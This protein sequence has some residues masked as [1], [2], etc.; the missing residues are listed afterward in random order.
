MLM[1][2]GRRGKGKSIAVTEIVL[3]RLRHHEKVYT[4]FPVAWVKGGQVVAQAGYVGSL[5]DCLDL[6]DCTIVVDEAPAWASVR[7]WQLLPSKVITDWMQS[8]K[9]HVQWVF[10]GTHEARVDVII[11]ELV[12]WV[13]LCSRVWW[14]PRWVP[15]FALCQTYYEDINEARRHK[16]GRRY[17][18]WYKQ[19][20]FDSYATDFEVAGMDVQKVKEFRQRIKD[21]APVDDF[22]GATRLE[23]VWYD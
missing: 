22:I 4:N 19:E 23:P 5:F 20:C 13:I 7:E 21:G 17:W 1:F 2:V 3:R 14:A 12:D 10:T 8:R 18:R 11:R 6:R 9:R 15:I 16:G